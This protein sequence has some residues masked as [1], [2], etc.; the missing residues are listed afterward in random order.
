MTMRTVSCRLYRPGA[1]P[2]GVESGFM[3]IPQAVVPAG[4]AKDGHAQEV[5]AAQADSQDNLSRFKATLT[6]A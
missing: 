6:C 5:H 4:H 2:V 1:V 3:L